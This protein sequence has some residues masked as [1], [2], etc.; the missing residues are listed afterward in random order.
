V[1]EMRREIAILN[2]IGLS[3][4]EIN[5]IFLRFIIVITMVGATIGITSSLIT[6]IPAISTNSRLVSLLL[7]TI[8]IT[9]MYLLSCLTIIFALKRI[10]KTNIIELLKSE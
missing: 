2:A 5:N 8:S 10:G 7:S 4:S 9:L 3:K 6:V 1:W